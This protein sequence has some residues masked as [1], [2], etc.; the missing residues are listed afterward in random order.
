[1][2]EN[3]TIVHIGAD[4]SE[5]AKATKELQNQFKNMGVTIENGMTNANDVIKQ[6]SNALNQQSVQL[7][8][9]GLQ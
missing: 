3:S 1:M 8:N 9:V 5:L 2:A 6:V 4:V 7:N